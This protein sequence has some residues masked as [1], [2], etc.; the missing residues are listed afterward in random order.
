MDS[1][2]LLGNLD[3]G[4]VIRVVG[5]GTMNDSPAFRA[6]ANLALGRGRLVCDMTDCEYLDSTFLGCLIGVQKQAEMQSRAS[7]VIAADQQ[8]RIKLFSTSA[9]DQYFHFSAESP[10]PVGKLVEIEGRE[11]D[12]EELGRHVLDCHRSLADRGGADGEVFR[13]VCDRLEEE[14]DEREI[15]ESRL[16]S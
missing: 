15:D 13:R 3:D 11:L 4:M 1:Q 5:R 9:L 10:E 14:L 2:L 16:G 6:A 7:F 8:A 12:R